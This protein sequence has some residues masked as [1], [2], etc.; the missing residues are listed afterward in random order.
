MQSAGH[1]FVAARNR[2]QTAS[3]F[4]AYLRG[5]GAPKV[6]VEPPGLRDHRRQHFELVAARS[7][8]QQ[9]QRLRVVEMNVGVQREID[10][11]RSF[12]RDVD[13]VSASAALVCNTR[14]LR[15]ARSPALTFK[16]L[17]QVGNLDT[18]IL[19]AMFADPSRDE[20][21]IIDLIV[22]DV[23]MEACRRIVEM[24]NCF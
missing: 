13:R 1:I 20:L 19:A 22:V 10:G 17:V 21:P 23:K 2:T 7:S 5:D 16:R 14:K 11:R 4:L 3:G 15:A 8:Q 9:S 12:E 18:R 24:A 6:A